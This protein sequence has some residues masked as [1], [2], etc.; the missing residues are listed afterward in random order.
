MTLFVDEA[1]GCSAERYWGEDNAAQP[2]LLIDDATQA[3]TEA[4]HRVRSG[5]VL[6]DRDLAAA[7]VALG[8]LFGGLGQLVALLS[9]SMVRSAESDPL[10]VGPLEDRLQTLRVM[11]LVAQQAA[12]GLQLRSA[13]SPPTD[14]DATIPSRRGWIR[15]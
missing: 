6:D 15:V 3:I 11:T 9:I 5:S 4:L 13:A 8:D 1:V 12:E 7:G 2:V 10:E 14:G